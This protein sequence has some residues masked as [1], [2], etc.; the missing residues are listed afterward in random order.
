MN[1]GATG[2]RTPHA[3]QSQRTMVLLVED[4]FLLRTMSIETLGDFGYDVVDAANADEAL[5]LLAERPEIGLLMT[6]IRLPGVGGVEL[7]VRA[8]RNR[9]DLRVLF[10][11]GYEAKSIA[12]LDTLTVPTAFIAKPYKPE[13]LETV[14]RD[15]LVQ[16]AS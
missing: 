9:P 10:A 4:D 5:A 14:L 7:A 12:G 16:T 1:P 13:Q 6:D 2:E 15:L 8:T 11:S 3:G